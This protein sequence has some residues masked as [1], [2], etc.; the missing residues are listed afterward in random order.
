M[1]G[2][3]RE[4]VY[5]PPC[6]GRSNWRIR[7]ADFQEIGRFAVKPL[8][9]FRQKLSFNSDRIEWVHDGGFLHNIVK[10]KTVLILLSHRSTID[11][12]IGYEMDTP[13]IIHI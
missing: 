7:D 12:V 13:S 4:A 8:V 6:P 2:G 9:A 5:Y 11:E 1:T 3:C 10:L